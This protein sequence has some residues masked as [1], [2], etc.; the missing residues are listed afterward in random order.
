MID[1]EDSLKDN[2]AK[3][4]KGLGGEECPS[5]PNPKT[6][7]HGEKLSELNVDKVKVAC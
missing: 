1:A 2:K 4:A 7:L 5:V 3:A 6:T